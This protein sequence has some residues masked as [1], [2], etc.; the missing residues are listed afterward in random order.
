M[1]PFDMYWWLVPLALALDVLWGD[2]PL[3]WRHPV[4]WIGKMYNWLEPLARRAGA[5]RPVGGMCVALVVGV[6]GTVVYVLTHLP[7]VGWLCALYLAY[8]G[9]SGECLVRTGREVIDVMAHGTLEEAQRALSMLVSRDTT[10]QDRVTLRKSTADTLSE[11]HTDAIVAPLFWL[12]VGGPVGMWMYK[13]V[14]TADSMWGYTTPQWLRLGCVGARADD[15]LAFVPARIGIFT[16]W[17]ADAYTGLSRRFGGRWPGWRCI[18]E[19]ASGMAS[20]NSGWPMAAAA[21]LLGQRMG[22]PTVYF[23]TLVPKPWVGAPQTSWEDWNDARLLALCRLLRVAY[24][25]GGGVLYAAGLL[26]AYTVR[27]L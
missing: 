26:L 5:S 12:I 14:S 17:L 18:R 9:L 22:G 10:V 1:L 23:G 24:V 21:W 8:A 20:P 27:I 6:T 16:L 15:V 7:G 3:P 13:A 11:N 2:P 19:Q 4:C 25:L